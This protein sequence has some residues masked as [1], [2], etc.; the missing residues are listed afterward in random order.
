MARPRA[1]T[2]EYFPH[3]VHH[4]KTLFI[5]EERFGDAGYTFWFKLLELL[6][7]SEGQ[8]Y[9]CGKDGAWE[10]L[11]AK[12]RHSEV[13]ATETL[14]LLAKLSA[15]DPE[16]W[17]QKV[18]WCQNFVERLK[19]LYA[20]RREE[21]PQRPSFGRKELGSPEVSDTETLTREVSDAE[22]C[23]SKVKESKVKESKVKKSKVKQS[24]DIDEVKTTSSTSAEKASPGLGTEAHRSSQKQTR[25]PYHEWT[26]EE[27]GDVKTV[28]QCQAKWD[29][30]Y[31]KFT[32]HIPVR[33]YGRDGGLFKKM[34]KAEWDIPNWIPRFFKW[35]S[36]KD[37]ELGGY[38]VGVFKAWVTRTD[39]EEVRLRREE[40]KRRLNE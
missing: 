26:D 15:I 35:V 27:I 1:K 9:D 4:G 6:G 25:K 18:I 19:P 24:K 34:L 32:G 20:K 31:F 33:D 22:T 14:D 37:E 3:D 17:E 40:R 12:T 30:S 23:Q 16:L 11:L 10:F 21:T 13:S 7:R 29:R 38:T 39:A 5:L 8:Y 28:D 2:I 36:E